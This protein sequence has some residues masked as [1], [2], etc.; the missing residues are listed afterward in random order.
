[1]ENKTKDFGN[2]VAYSRYL[3][4][5]L[6]IFQ[7]LTRINESSRSSLAEL[8]ISIHQ[9]YLHHTWDGSGW[10]LDTDSIGGDKLQIGRK[11]KSLLNNYVNQSYS[12]YA[13]NVLQC[14]KRGEVR[15][16]IDISQETN[17]KL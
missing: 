13:I 2:L 9:C 10:S 4:K 17:G 11:K 8:F 16:S 5:L 7:W 14:G 6:C 12:V 15:T 3:F 1:M